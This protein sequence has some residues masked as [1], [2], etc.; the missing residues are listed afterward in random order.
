MVSQADRRASTVAAII[1][2]ARKLFTA[3]G[4]EATT[5]DDVVAKAGVAKGA[6]YHHFSS[7]EELFTR[8]LESVQEE[9]AAGHKP[10]AE[11]KVHD[12]K[13]MIAAGVQRYLLDA[14]DPTRKRILLIDGPAIIGWRKWREIDDRY[15]GA[16]ARAAM[17]RVMGE[18]APARQIDAATHLLMG[19]VMEASLVCATAAD[20][21]KSARELSA[22][23]R[24]MLEGLRSV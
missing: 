5:M 7:K 21:K 20:P 18:N 2:A 14:T 16:G 15:F 23:L 12:P 6:I 13:D 3:N 17:A 19:A 24:E 9:I 1:A 10:Q 8:V 22:S 11:T 4:F